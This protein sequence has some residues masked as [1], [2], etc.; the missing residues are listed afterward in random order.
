MGVTTTADEMLR[1]TRDNIQSAIINIREVLDPDTW[2][3]SDLQES[4][5]EELEEVYLK[6]LRIKKKL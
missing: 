2:G 4:Y 5:I 6:L 1:E 3:H